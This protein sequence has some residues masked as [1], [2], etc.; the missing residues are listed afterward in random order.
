M[1]RFL[2]FLSFV[3]SMA[4]ML[5]SCSSSNK[6]KTEEKKPFVS[7]KQLFAVKGNV[8]QLC[9]GNDGVEVSRVIFDRQGKVIAWYRDIVNPYRVDT[10]PVSFERDANGRICKIEEQYIYKSYYDDEEPTVMNKQKQL[11]YNEDGRLWMEKME[12]ETIQYTAYDEHGTPT[13]YN[14]I[15]TLADMTR[16]TISYSEIDD[17]GNWLNAHHT[18]YD[19]EDTPRWTSDE[20]RTITYYSP[21]SFA[22]NFAAEATARYQYD[23]R[24]RDDSLASKVR[25]Y[26]DRVEEKR[27]E[28]ERQAEEMQQQGDRI[29]QAIQG[30][31]D[32]RGELSDGTTVTLAIFVFDGQEGY[33]FNN[34]K[35]TCN[36]GQLDLVPSSDGGFEMQIKNRVIAYVRVGGS[37]VSADNFRMVKVSDSVDRPND[38]KYYKS[39]MCATMGNYGI[40]DQYVFHSL[41]E[42]RAYDNDGR[43][44]WTIIE[45]GSN[46]IEKKFAC[47]L[48]SEGGTD[49]RR[50]TI[51]I[52]YYG[53]DTRTGNQAKITQEYHMDNGKYSFYYY[54]SDDDYWM[55]NCELMQF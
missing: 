52:F 45:R 46:K 23:L 55:Y 49:R 8:K 22:D 39:A 17:Q 5:F 44:E 40:K 1:K 28:E 54:I 29:R 53:Q 35:R 36:Y 12:T 18:I 9:Y 33:V 19:E 27:A 7:D 34:K 30:T 48:P 10:R 21:V 47:G 51:G 25:Y 32:A 43:S 42:H 24:E 2:L 16:S 41:I 11:F 15:L 4:L 31:W 14:R 37:L 3:M 13:Q 20:H 38:L 26:S 6:Q 50:Q